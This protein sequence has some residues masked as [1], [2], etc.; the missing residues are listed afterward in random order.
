VAAGEGCGR[1]CSRRKGG[2]TQYL[3]LS[4][5]LVA[6]NNVEAYPLMLTKYD[7]TSEFLGCEVRL[8]R[9]YVRTERV[10]VGVVWENSPGR[11]FQDSHGR[12]YAMTGQHLSGS[13]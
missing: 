9:Q 12:E 3:C 6:F 2:G 5:L 4:E 10:Y 11:D 8:M 13:Q 1:D 7:S